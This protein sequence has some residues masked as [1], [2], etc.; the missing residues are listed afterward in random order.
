KGLMVLRLKAGSVT[1]SWA[2]AP[3]IP[4]L[5][6]TAEDFHRPKRIDLMPYFRAR[7]HGV[8][9]EVDS[10]E[11]PADALTRVNIA[12]IA[13]VHSVLPAFPVPFLLRPA[14][15]P[16]T[17]PPGFLHTVSIAGSVE[18]SR[19]FVFADSTT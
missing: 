18:A 5:I 2:L 7:L 15:A 19:V 8:L 11:K 9:I 4:V 12:N 16:S 10:N 17:I 13:Q 3:S 6:L 1:A 14:P